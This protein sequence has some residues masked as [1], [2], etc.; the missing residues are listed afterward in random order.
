MKSIMIFTIIILGILLSTNTGFSQIIY[1]DDFEGG[2]NIN[3]IP[4]FYSNINEEWE[5]NLEIVTNP[6]GTGNVGKVLDADTSNTGAALSGG[7]V[8]DFANISIEADVYCYVNTGSNTSKYTGI[9]LMADTNMSESGTISN[10]YVKMVADFDDNTSAGPRIR[11]YNNDL[12]MTTFQ[13]SFDVKFYADDI[14]GGIPTEDGW[15]RM[16]LEA[17]TLNPDSVEY[18]LYFDGNL[19]G[20]G[21]VYDHTYNINDTTLHMPFTPGTFGLFAFQQG[22]ALPGYFDDVQVEELVTSIDS[23]RK[24]VIEGYAL[25]QNYPNPFNPTTTIKFDLPSAQLLQLEVFNIVGQRVRTLAASE[26]SAGSHQ[27]KWDAKDDDGHRVPAGLYYYRL[28][29]GDFEQTRKMLL[30]K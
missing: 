30:V 6:F 1:Q 26:Y 8:F 27:L 29:A 23:N 3:W 25:H 17:K 12:N 19:V 14:P 13:Y 15:H 18:T 11:L 2:G 9:A 21:P 24:I 16:R 28:R 4:L 7:D 5:D 22:A 20:G 10:K